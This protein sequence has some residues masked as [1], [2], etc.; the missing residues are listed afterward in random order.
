MV[1]GVSMPRRCLEVR[2]IDKKREVA[3]GVRFPLFA[4]LWYRSVDHGVYLRPP[5]QI[6]SSGLRY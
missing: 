6:P 4:H 3:N 5:N 1:R 2:V